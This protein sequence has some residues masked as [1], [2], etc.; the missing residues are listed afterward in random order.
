M[1]NFFLLGLK[2]YIVHN[3]KNIYITSFLDGNKRF[4]TPFWSGY[5]CKNIVK[6]IELKKKIIFEDSIDHFQKGIHHFC[7]E[8]EYYMTIWITSF[9]K[10]VSIDDGKNVLCI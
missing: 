9:A 6:A 1:Y 2:I 4:V 8:C 5:F 10:L 3:R 7:G